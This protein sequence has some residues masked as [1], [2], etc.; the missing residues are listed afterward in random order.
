MSRRTIVPSSRR[1]PLAALVG[2]AMVLGLAACGGGGNKPAENTGGGSVDHL[3]ARV[4]GPTFTDLPTVVILAQDYFKKVGLDVDFD[5]LAASN[6][7]N[8]TQGVIAG[9]MDITTGGSGSLYS[10]Y[11]AGRHELVA[12]GNLNPAM[13][14][15]VAVN[16]KAVEEMAK[17]GVTKNSP[18]EKRV[19]ALRGMKFAASPAGSTGLK[20]LRTM[21]TS[22]GVN[23][24]SD[25]TIVGNSDNNAQ[26]AAARAGQV[27]GFANSFPNSNMAEADGWGVLWLNFAE[28]LPKG[29]LIPL[30]SHAL[31]TTHD[32]LNKHPQAAE[33]LLR[34]YW[35]AQVDLQNPTPE[36]KEKI[37]N[38]PAF[39]NLNPKG[40]DLGWDASIPIY[41]GW[42]PVP[43]QEMFTKQLDLV[44]LDAATKI[45]FKFADLY[46]LGPANKTKPA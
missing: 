12:I 42:T 23:P 21:F 2:L 41:K 46:D 16:N 19:Q 33:K 5:F 22:Y 27:D 9:E 30:A 43:T 14:F 20:Y 15:G 31:Y 8:A 29:S 45:D 38:L 3:V 44:N 28:D 1:A 32:W 36:L 7:A 4:T 26:L 10:A 24:D 17:K 34:A 40:F 39:K 35:L 11:A 37:K 18:V 6:A 13:T 25:V